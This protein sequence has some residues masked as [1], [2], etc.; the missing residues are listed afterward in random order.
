[1][2]NPRTMSIGLI[3]NNKHT[4]ID[5]CIGHNLSLRR[6]IQ[7]AVIIVW[8]LWK[9]YNHDTNNNNRC[10]YIYYVSIKCTVNCIEHII[11]RELSR[12]TRLSKVRVIDISAK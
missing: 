6:V 10:I 11:T 1:M 4:S 3:W 7:V 8:V 12:L 9:P 5:V 2:D